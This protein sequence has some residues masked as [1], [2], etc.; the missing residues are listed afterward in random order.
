MIDIHSHIRED[1]H[2]SAAAKREIQARFVD[3]MPERGSLALP[4]MG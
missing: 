4:G 1:G 3:A 2:F